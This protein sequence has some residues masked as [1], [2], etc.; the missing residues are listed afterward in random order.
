M[1]TRMTYPPSSSFH[2]R[3][4]PITIAIL[5]GVILFTS[6]FFANFAKKQIR[7]LGIKRIT[8]IKIKR[9]KKNFIKK[10]N[11]QYTISIIS[12][13]NVTLLRNAS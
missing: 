9:E 3:F 6:E 4:G 7:Y 10:N 8:K 1:N 11:F 2:K 13:G 12:L 5:L